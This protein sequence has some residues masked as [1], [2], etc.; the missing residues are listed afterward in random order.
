MVTKEQVVF[1][2]NRHA[3]I[4][5]EKAQLDQVGAAQAGTGYAKRIALT[6]EAEENTLEAEA[7]AKALE[8]VQATESW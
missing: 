1:F 6:N 5:A 8:V 4:T 7:M 3:K 2:L